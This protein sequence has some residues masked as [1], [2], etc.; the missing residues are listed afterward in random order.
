MAF[1][2]T[3]RWFGPNDP[4]SLK[5]IK[6]TGATGIVS[7]LHHI[8]VGEVWSVEEILIRKKIIEEEGL[9]WSV[10]ESLPVHE[11]IKKRKANYEQ[12]IENY[13][14]SL[15]NLAKCGLDIICY[16]FMPILDWSRTDLKVVFRDGS[17]TSKFESRKFAAFDLFILKR[18]HAFKDYSE[19]Q[20]ARAKEFFDLL[21]PEEIQNLKDTVLLGLP[22][23]LEAL[24]LEQFRKA[25]KEYD[26]IDE[27]KL[28]YNLHQFIKAVAPIAEEAG[29]YLVIHADD[30]P[31]GLLGLPR[32]VKNKFDVKGILDAYDSPHNGLTL[33]TGSFGADVKNDLV[34][35][36][37]L[38]AHRINFVHL[39]NLSRNEQG[40]FLEENHLDGD[41]DIF[42]VMK[43]LL[44]EQ[45]K[46]LEQGRKDNRFPLRP[47]HGH[48]MIPDMNREGIYPGYSL[49]GRMRG[50]SELRGVELGIRRSLNL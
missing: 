25:L 48:L 23:S 17:I 18:A 35:L 38:F 24:T 16:N 34:E 46:R 45:K 49:F 31:W 30:P 9:T 3:W 33:C 47:D 2:Q 36:T 37:E 11:N 20:V 22:G 32:V 19:E 5:E 13:K 28:R 4:I 1:E 42:G 26:D 41:I 29:M 27:N 21:K 12:L 50:L 44:I 6:Q 10:V 15:K 39:R 40:D 7:A 14:V 8:P 43:T